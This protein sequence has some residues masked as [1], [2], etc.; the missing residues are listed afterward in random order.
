MGH[1]P[2]REQGVQTL[3]PSR[4]RQRTTQAIQRIFHR[5]GTAMYCRASAQ[6][7]RSEA[8]FPKEAEGQSSRVCAR[9]ALQQVRPR[10]RVGHVP[11]HEQDV[12]WP[13]VHILHKLHLR[14]QSSTPHAIA[15]ARNPEGL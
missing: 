10:R 6:Q 7:R 5:F 14:Q 11:G 1:R 8:G 13:G 4:L 2:A 12:K 9:E 3:P 15:L